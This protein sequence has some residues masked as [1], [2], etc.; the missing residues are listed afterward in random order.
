[1]TE[2][3]V[4]TESCG[5]VGMTFRTWDDGSVR[6]DIEFTNGNCQIAQLFLLDI[7]AAHA[8]AASINEAVTSSSTGDFEL[9]YEISEHRSIEQD[10]VLSVHNADGQEVFRYK[11][12]AYPPDCGRWGLARIYVFGAGKRGPCLMDG[13]VRNLALAKCLADAMARHWRK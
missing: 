5:P 3:H 10:E 4:T 9:A 7:E 11:V 13:T 12:V 8:A 2:P 1:M 6:L